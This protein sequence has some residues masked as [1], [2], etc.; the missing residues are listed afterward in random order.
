MWKVDQNAYGSI[1][2][3]PVYGRLGWVRNIAPNLSRSKTWVGDP[4]KWNGLYWN[5]FLE[6]EP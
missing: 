4:S 6:K 2:F 5:A 1:A 3:V